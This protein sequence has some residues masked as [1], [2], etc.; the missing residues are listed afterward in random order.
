MLGI[1][2][3]GVELLI[4]KRAE[5]HPR[6]GL[7]KLLRFEQPP[8]STLTSLRPSNSTCLRTDLENSNIGSVNKSQ[9]PSKHKPD[10]GLNE[11]AYSQPK[12]TQ[13]LPFPISRETR[14][15][16]HC[17]PG[18]TLSE[19][20]WRDTGGIHWRI[21]A[22]RSGLILGGY[23]AG[24]TGK[25]YSAGYSAG[26]TGELLCGILSGIL[27]GIQ[28]RATVWDP[29]ASYSGGILG[30]IHWRASLAEY[31]AGSTGEPLW[32]NTR[33]DPL[34]S[35][36]AGYSAGSTGEPLW[37]DTRR[38][39]LASSSGGILGGIHWQAAL[40]GYSAG[41]TD[42]LPLESCSGGILGGGVV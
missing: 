33:R 41:S 23:S 15:Q 26:S 40:A 31:S 6:D 11:V 38:D 27:G 19:L 21:M 5:N 3:K 35:G 29:L 20:F 30:G 32:Q 4:S 22:S 10:G 16:P 1:L 2:W 18:G 25:G 37:W 39:P 28:W 12:A 36:S 34:A 24:S 14:G 8:P 7:R 42:E 17:A 13:K 9:A